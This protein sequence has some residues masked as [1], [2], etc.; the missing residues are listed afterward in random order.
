M[1][2]SESYSSKKNEDIC[3][4]NDGTVTNVGQA[5]EK[6]YLDYC[7][8]LDPKICEEINGNWQECVPPGCDPSGICIMVECIV[9][10]ACVLYDEK[11]YQQEIELQEFQR[12]ITNVS[13]IGMVIIGIA[14]VY[15]L[16]KNKNKKT[17]ET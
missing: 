8:D 11:I 16:W 4:L 10:D 17:L 14:L 7:M 13:I 15:K 9:H 2:I 5:F 12:N 1:G 6:N 3:K